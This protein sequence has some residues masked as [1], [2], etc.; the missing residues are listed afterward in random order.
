MSL[1]EVEQVKLRANAIDRASTAA[2][3]AGVILPLA[4]L[5]LLPGRIAVADVVANAYIW[6]AAA[7]A[8]HV[9]ARRTLRRLE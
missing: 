7:Y 4:G 2:L 3:N 1:G 5:T 9:M 6:G 8:L